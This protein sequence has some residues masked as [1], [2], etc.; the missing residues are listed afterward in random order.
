MLSNQWFVIAVGN[1]LS[2]VDTDALPADRRTS[3]LSGNN[4]S[5]T[6]F[7]GSAVLVED[8]G[9]AY[10]L[11]VGD[12]RSLSG[13][14]NFRTAGPSRHA[15]LCTIDK[16]TQSLRVLT[17][18]L[19]FSKIF[20]YKLN[21]DGF[22]LATHLTFFNRRTLPLSVSGVACNLANGTEFNNNTVFRDI[23]VLQRASVHEFQGN[24]STST[25]Y[26]HYGFDTPV[27][28]GSARQTLHDCLIEAVRDQICDR[29]VLLSLSGG[30]D[31]SGILGILA[32]F[33]KPHSLKTF[34]YVNGVPVKGSDAAVAKNMATLT[35][36]PHQDIQAYDG[37]F[38]ATIRRNAQTGQGLSNFCDEMDAWHRQGQ[39][40]A[41]S[42][43][44]AGDECF[45]WADRRLVS[46]DD[47]LVSVCLR[48]FD[49]AGAVLPYLDPN[50]GRQL[51]DALNADVD[52]IVAANSQS[53]L[54]DMKD[55][56]YLDH[57]VQWGLLPWRRFVIGEYFEV[58]EPFLQT[59]VLDLISTLPASDRIG[60]A[61]YRQVIQE[62]VPE[63]FSI[64][65]A[66]TNQAG[67]QWRNEI[68][69]SRS[70]I[71]ESL[72]TPSGLDAMISPS[73]ILAL[74]DAIK[75]STEPK[76]NWK[77][78]VRRIVGPAATRALRSFVRPEGPKAVPIHTMLIRLLV[79]REFLAAR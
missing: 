50:V 36:Y 58:R 8:T 16:K 44:L 61:L 23:D 68:L 47:V 30:F 53:K 25:K 1:G 46:T 32:K 74:L 51:E 45:G 22:V 63:V 79:L 31:S 77:L 38:L 21:N 56:L 48:K 55:A 65:R 20:R 62:M 12:T 71:A 37:D 42:V 19:N 54:H 59:Q 11:A 17:D 75:D 26:W 57:R 14:A 69:K 13:L 60:K 41:G 70:S 40:E 64:P 6:I 43:V 15:V 27:A 78:T 35:G 9:D 10:S 52:R 39:N 5:T 4:S 7:H 72:K 76:Q 66:R 28:P 3:V 34:S 24:Q 73:A 49:L 29:P 2:V 33:V 18:R 67:P